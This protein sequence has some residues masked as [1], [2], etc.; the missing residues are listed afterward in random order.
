MKLFHIYW[1]N[2]LYDPF[3]EMV[4]DVENVNFK[5]KKRNKSKSYD[6]LILLANASYMFIEHF[7]LNEIIV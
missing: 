2:I 7:K 6:I 4:A 1:R 3:R 5:A